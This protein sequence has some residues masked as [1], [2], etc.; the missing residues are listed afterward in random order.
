VIAILGR[1]YG[2]RRWTRFE[3]EQFEEL[4]GEHRVIP[5]WAKDAMPTAFDLTTDVGGATFDPASDLDSQ[6][7]AVAELCGRKLDDIADAPQQ[8]LPV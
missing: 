1:Q 2:Q 3:S 5:I 7:R 8:A 4:F 6:A